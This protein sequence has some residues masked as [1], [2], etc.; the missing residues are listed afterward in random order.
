MSLY[1][2]SLSGFSAFHS[3]TGHHTPE[4]FL[5]ETDPYSLEV[6][7]KILDSRIELNLE[8]Y[9]TV[10]KEDGHS[11]F[12]EGSR[13][14]EQK[15]KGNFR[16][17]LTNKPL[18]VYYF[19]VYSQQT[20]SFEYY[21]DASQV[22]DSVFYYPILISD[23]T[24]PLEDRWDYCHKMGCI[25]LQ[26]KH[27]NLE[28]ALGYLEQAA[29][30]G[31]K[32]SQ[33]MLATVNFENDDQKKGVFWFKAYLKGIKPEPIELIFL[34]TQLRKENLSEAIELFEQAALMGNSIAVANLIDIYEQLENQQSA[35]K[36][37]EQLP[38]EWKFSFMKD[39]IQHLKDAKYNPNT[40]NLKNVA[41]I[42]LL[43]QNLNTV[44]DF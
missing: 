7:K 28:K 15:F 17:P 19:L 40:N 38:N 14:I 13:F 44:I 9:I 29:K 36:W 39:F 34:A 5:N 10:I 1:I 21:C 20:A 18:D 6:F 4:A 26:P 12:V 25:Y 22:E 30:A 41:K 33:K 32:K 2:K 8:L 31:L 11:F 24:R 37:R 42:N 27:R 3:I 16:N 35:T 43:S 23:H